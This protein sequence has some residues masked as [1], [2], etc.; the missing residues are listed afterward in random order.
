MVFIEKRARR[1]AVGGAAVARSTEGVC[2]CP[3]S[4]DGSNPSPQ[5][6]SRLLHPRLAPSELIEV[7]AEEAADDT[8]TTETAKPKRRRGSRGGRGR[9]KPGEAPAASA[10][11]TPAPRTK[12]RAA[13][14]KK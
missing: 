1:P 6:M 11:E 3:G 14:E 4:V 13:A 10:G 2:T 12:A 7:A 5:P 9:K 8:D